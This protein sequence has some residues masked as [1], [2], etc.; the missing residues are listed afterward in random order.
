MVAGVDARPGDGGAERLKRYWLTEG[1]PKWATK[2]HP[3]QALVDHLVK[4]VSLAVAKG[5][6]TE[7]YHAHFG[8]YP[9]SDTAHLRSGAPIRGKVVGPG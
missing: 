7:L 4:Y 5:L 2:P 9:G 8:D 3:W 6:A 1:L